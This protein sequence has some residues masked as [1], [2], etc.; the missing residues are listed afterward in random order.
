MTDVRKERERERENV[1]EVSALGSKYVWT[2]GQRVH[3][4]KAFEESFKSHSQSRVVTMVGSW[5]L[6]GSMH[7]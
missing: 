1:G 7:F 5:L 3:R 4:H 6:E 2:H